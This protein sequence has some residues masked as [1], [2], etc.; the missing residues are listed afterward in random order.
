L[1]LQANSAKHKSF[2]R[3]IGYRKKGASASADHS[4]QR[5]P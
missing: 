5:Q 3:R 1:K 2:I 4:A